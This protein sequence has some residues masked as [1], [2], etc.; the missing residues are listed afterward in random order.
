MS[1]LAVLF[2]AADTLLIDNALVVSSLKTG[3]EIGES[4]SNV[5]VVTMTDVR[6]QPSLNV[7]DV[8]S[9]EPGLSRGGDGIWSANINVHGFSE[10]RLVTLI[11]RNRV[12]TA[13]DL[14]ASLSMLNVYDVERVEVIKG[15][16][17]SIYGS[18]A[19]G[20]IVNVITR[21]GHFADKPYFCGNFTSSYTSM[22]S[23]FGEY[24]S[25]Y[26][27]SRKWYIKLHGAY[28]SAGD[29]RTPEGYLRNSSFNSADAGATAAF[30]ITSAGSIKMQFQR[31][32]SWDVGIPGGASFSPA[33][34]ASYSSI[35]R[36]L[37]SINYDADDLG[38]AWKHLNVKL[39][40]QGIDRDV[41]MLPN[42]P[43]PQSGARPVRVTP[44]AVHDT[45][46][47]SAEGRWKHG[48]WN[49]LTAG[50]EV[51]SRSVSSQRA[52]YIDQYAAGVV[53]A[54][55]IRR[56]MPLP[57]ASYT[58]SG[59]FAQDEMRL[60]E[61]RLVLSMGVR[62][63]VNFV[64]NGECHSVE[65]IENV[66]AGTVN[67]NPPGKF[68]T[69]EAGRRTDPSWSANFGL[70]YRTGSRLDLN[71]NLTRAYRSPAIEELFK[72]IDLSGNKVHFGNPD[73]KPEKCL[74]A[75]AGLRYHS[76][77]L[78]FNL[79]AYVNGISDMIVERRENLLPESVNDTL[80]LHNASRAVLY[81]LDGDF[82]CKIGG[83]VT[84]FAVCSLTVGTELSDKNESL[85]LIPPFSGRAGLQYDNQKSLGA[86][87]EIVASGAR[88]SGKIADGER[89]TDAWWRLDAS[90]HSRIFRLG[91]CSLQL[92]GGMNNITDN[93][94]TNFLSTNRGNIVCEPGRNLY[95]RANLVF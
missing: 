39:F 27:G 46:G 1:V 54:Q 37:A 33:A 20:G 65:L 47:A 56:E 75:D 90:L 77:R 73:L 42:A 81:G 80:V 12:E 91:C 72:F 11:D 67:D 85:P 76:D 9:G 45:Y 36:T 25:L 70:L 71:F 32:Q 94:Y 49:S 52:K 19:I 29:A 83:G 89:A 87:V 8:L 23:G 2:V 34:T 48:G 57:D 40:Y 22:N 64:K 50:A 95:L 44:G 4:A 53:K 13:T 41:T 79:S 58:S 35:G 84:A 15:A 30:R 86:S 55:M 43:E 74:G 88:P 5:S 16:Q 51:W 93:S 61:G 26:G 24:M 7:A 69:F 62:A 82:S 14:T 31:N 18:G 66:T 38:D 17:S 21:D 60:L 3:G 59:I 78:R 68:V 6:R 10:N 92:F 28:S 63:D